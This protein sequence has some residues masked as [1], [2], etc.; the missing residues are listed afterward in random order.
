[1]PIALRYCGLF[2]VLLSLIGSARGAVAV[3]AGCTEQAF[4]NAVAA[5]DTVSFTNDCTITLTG[6]V[7]ISGN[8]TID[9]AGHTVT[10][11]GGNAVPLFNVKGT[12][13][14]LGLTLADGKN[15]QGGAVYV[16]SGATAIANNCTFLGNSAIGT[17]GTAG[18]NGSDNP[19]GS[20]GNGGSGTAGTAGLGG[21]IYNLGDIALWNCVLVTNTATGGNGGTGG[22]G[23]DGG[24]S[25]G[26]GGNGGNG[27]AGGFGQGGAVYNLGNLSLFNC[28]LS[29]NI[30][31]GGTGGKGGTNGNALFPGLIGKG[32]AGATGAGGAVFNARN[33][34]ILGCT[35]SANSAKGGASAAGGN[36]SNGIGT[37]GLPGG[38]AAGGALSSV[39]WGAITNC[40]F[41]SNTVAGGTGGNGGDGT[42]TASTAGT[43]GNG[44]NGFGGGIENELTL[45]VV[46]C[47]LSTC[48][49]VGGTN[50]V[51]GSG[52]FN[53]SNGNPGQA[54]GGNIS[55]VAGTLMLANSILTASPS[56]GNGYGFV[57]DKGYNISSDSTLNLS[58]TSKSNKAPK[59]VALANNGGSTLTMALQTGSPALN[60]IPRDHG[61]F[62]ATDQ[63]G[64]ERPQ[65]AGADAGAFEVMTAVESF[66]IQPPTLVSNSIVIVF[67]TSTNL[68]YILQYKNDLTDTNWTG[69]NTNTG[70]GN[71]ITNQDS[72]TTQTS[73]FYRVQAK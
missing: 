19:D 42:G 63:R 31:T 12:L 73:R 46:N 4:T 44:G 15:Q 13:N 50:G 28:T 52:I 37:D 38:D 62:P 1:M 61:G 49:A 41:Y 54:R 55:G 16:N 71:L 34:T 60:I 5:G 30:A 65:G 43:G 70:T 40:T 25:L 56:G 22:G 11:S 33:T 64:I 69:L 39:W 57:T 24:G 58:G 14:L 2:C 72:T 21:A 27:G 8:T 59:L 6:P 48:S 17:N 32:G 51:A 36:R 47:T 45:T 67:P 53:G 3:V 66:R 26:Q 10:I 18:S 68:T 35:F 7:Q 23:G 9:A 20:G 29:N